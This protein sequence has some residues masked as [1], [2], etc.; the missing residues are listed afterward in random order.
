MQ[1][2]GVAARGMQRISAPFPPS[3]L[4][5][6]AAAAAPLTSQGADRGVHSCDSIFYRFNTETEVGWDSPDHSSVT[7]V[8]W[9]CFF[10]SPKR[11]SKEITSRR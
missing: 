8:F 10:K 3:A 5:D 2:A 7:K 1:G 9:F 11:F 4:Q 6:S